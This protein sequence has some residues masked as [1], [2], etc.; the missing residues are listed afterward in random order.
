MSKA[1]DTL[2]LRIRQLRQDQG[3]SIAALAKRSG[4]PVSTISKIENG[5]L[6]PSLVNAINLATALQ[7]NLGFL[8]DRTRTQHARYS[9]VRRNQRGRRSFPEMAL[10]LEDLSSGFVP[11]LLES[12]IGTIGPGAH[13]GEEFMSHPGEE[14]AHVL[15]GR[16]TYD[17]DGT[18]VEIAQGDSLHFQSDTPHRW[19][20]DS[21]GPAELLWVFSDGLSF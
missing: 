12:R 15:S 3:L 10:V 21:D 20:N 18:I 16:I 14:L 19:Y 17:I 4:V 2:G 8:L 9:V 11:G 5:L 6:K 1:A 13:S 7:A